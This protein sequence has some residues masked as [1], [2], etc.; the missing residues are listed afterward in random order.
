MFLFDG[1]WFGKNI[2]GMNTLKDLETGVKRKK[3][4]Q[5]RSENLLMRL[6]S[7]DS[8]LDF[9]LNL[10]WLIQKVSFSEIARIG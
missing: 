10:K 8:N 3:N 9:E 4:F 2:Q 5:V 7:G 1:D 6:Q